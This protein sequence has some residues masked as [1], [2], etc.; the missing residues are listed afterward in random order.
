MFNSRFVLYLSLLLAVVA[1]IA[2]GT[3]GA[4]ADNN[5]VTP[6]KTWS[7]SVDDPE[8]LRDAPACIAHQTMLEKL[9]KV[10][11]IPDPLPKVDFNKEIV[12]VIT[13][14]GSMLQFESIILNDRGDLK[15]NA[16]ESLDMVP[17][18]RYIIATVSREGV[19]TVNGKEVPKVA[20]TI[21]SR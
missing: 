13:G 4:W 8:L 2:L 18:F 20:I 3:S 12:L 17:G 10:W 6:S 1:V 11:A 19:K 14:S 21:A 7:G 16:M 9:W 5:D 15:V